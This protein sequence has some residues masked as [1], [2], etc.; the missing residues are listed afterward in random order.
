MVAS[1]LDVGRPRVAVTDSGK[2]EG[3][4]G[5]QVAAKDATNEQDTKAGRAD[6]T[7]KPSRAF[8]LI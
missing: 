3:E 4:I 8:L 6:L 5:G 2:N 1:G 7:G